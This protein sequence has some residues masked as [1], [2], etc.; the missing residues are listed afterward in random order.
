MHLRPAS[1]ASTKAID[2]LRFFIEES[3]E[4]VVASATAARNSAFPHFTASRHVLAN[5]VNGITVSGLDAT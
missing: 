5:D 2:R 3:E 4:I 1:D